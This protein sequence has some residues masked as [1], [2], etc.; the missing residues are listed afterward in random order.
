MSGPLDSNRALDD[1]GIIQAGGIADLLAGADIQQVIASPAL[2]CVQTVEP[3]A[4]KLNLGVEISHDL[5]EG[6]PSLAAIGLAERLAGGGVTAV[7]CSHGDI[8]PGM[9][10]GFAARGIHLDGSGCAK[11][12]VWSMEVVD[13]AIVAGAYRPGV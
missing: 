4:D 11:G 1:V 7:L 3:L 13:G 10:D 2:R 5:W 12:S 6:Q 9:L 8:I